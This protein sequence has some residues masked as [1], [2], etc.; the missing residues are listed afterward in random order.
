M[1][2]G[3]RLEAGGSDESLPHVSREAVDVHVVDQPAGRGEQH[4]RVGADLGDRICSARVVRPQ[5][6]R[7]LDGIATHSSDLSGNVERGRHLRRN[8]GESVVRQYHVEVG[9]SADHVGAG[10][11]VH[12]ARIL[13]RHRDPIRA[14]L[15]HGG[16]DDI[17]GSPAL[18]DALIG[19]ANQSVAGVE[20]VPHRVLGTHRED[21]APLECRV[22]ALTRQRRRI[23]RGVDHGVADGAVH[24][25]GVD[26][27]ASGNEACDG[28]IEG[29]R[30][31]VRHV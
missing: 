17:A 29:T 9:S 8:R 19:K 4:A 15:V 16:Q 26:L 11:V 5:G 22:R 20:A 28:E 23:G 12:L 7:N 2:E 6:V 13:A 30:S 25:V 1:L 14:V 21:G 18:E 24:D 27:A 10:T 31:I 3:V